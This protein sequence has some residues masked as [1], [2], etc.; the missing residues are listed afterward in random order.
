MN[1]IAIFLVVGAVFVA[2]GIVVGSTANVFPVQASAEAASVDALFNFLLVIAVV[3]F[4]IVE[5][6]IVYSVIRFRKRKGDESDGAPIHGNTALEITWTAIPAVVVFVLAIYSYQVFVETRTPRE[7]Q[8]VVGVIGA[9]F[10]WQFRYP[11]P[12]DD[13]PEIT[14]E[15]RDRIQQFMVAP[16]LY[17]PVGRPVRADIESRDV[18]HSFFVPA[19]RVKEDAIPGRV[20]NAYFTPI[21]IGEYPV[22]CAELCGVGHGEMSLINRVFVTEQAEYDR[23]VADLYARAVEAATNPRLPE[24]GRQLF[25]QYPCGNCHMNADLGT[26][27]VLGPDLSNIGAVAEERAAQGVPGIVPPGDAE[28][29]DSPAANYIRGSIVNPNAYLVSGYPAN[30]MPQNYGDPRIMPR[31]HLEAIVNY[32]LTLR[33]E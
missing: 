22:K 14:P 2:I 11:V 23:F 3:V 13:N 25:L 21:E 8:L 20:T 9:Q 6:G 30:L 4:L 33:Q 16:D 12:E 1:R 17:L 29:V 32:L 7:G 15:L 5:G 28:G 24:V 31:D 10:Q 26:M 27:A 19:F 18:I